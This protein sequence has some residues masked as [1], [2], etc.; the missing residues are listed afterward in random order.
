[1][2]SVRVMTVCAA[3]AVWIGSL[4]GVAARFAPSP[5]PAGEQGGPP[6]PAAA[7]AQVSKTADWTVLAPEDGGKALFL[8]RCHMCHNLATVL[9]TRG[10]REFWAGSVTSMIPYGARIPYKDIEPLVAY[11][12]T[13]FGPDKPRLIVPIDINTASKAVLGL[14]APIASHAEAIVRARENG[15]LF[16]SAEDLI[17][18]DGITAEELKKVRPFI[19]GR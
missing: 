11:L 1:M 6:A 12:S 15:R 10:D 8:K 18:F 9:A 19:T 16:K 17:G 7:K 2:S 13:H 4:A 5:A 14:L 3:A